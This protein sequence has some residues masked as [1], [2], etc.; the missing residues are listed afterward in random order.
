MKTTDRR[1]VLKAGL[2]GLAG[3]ASVPV[4]GGLAG[5]QQ[6]ASRESGGSAPARTSARPAA[7][8]TEKLG[9]RVTV[10]VG[11]PGNVIALAAEDGVVLVDSGAENA[12]RAVKAKLGGAKVRTLFNTH[13]HA[14]Q[15]GGNALFGKDGAAIH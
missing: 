8:T 13:Y 15:T 14:D 6:L 4:L 1:S 2:G 7:L 3:F 12:A 11:A 5:C 10:I 9:E